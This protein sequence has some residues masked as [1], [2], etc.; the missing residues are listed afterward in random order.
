M[1]AIGSRAPVRTVLPRP[2]GLP[3]ADSEDNLKP[4]DDRRRVRAAV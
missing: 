4:P 3:I 1:L 2:D